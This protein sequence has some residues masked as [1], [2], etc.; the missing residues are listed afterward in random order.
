[1]APGD[2]LARLAT[3]LDDGNGDAVDLVREAETAL[4]AALG[5]ERY[6]RL[7]AAIES[8]DFDAALAM[9]KERAE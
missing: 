7:A 4:R 8:F 5:D 3:L 1:V 9:L 2:A 6:G